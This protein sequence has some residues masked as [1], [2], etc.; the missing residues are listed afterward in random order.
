MD[1][2]V[3]NSYQTELIVNYVLM[4]ENQ[5]GV[6]INRSLLESTWK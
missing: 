6:K 2:E 5:N 1:F 4:Y 3:G